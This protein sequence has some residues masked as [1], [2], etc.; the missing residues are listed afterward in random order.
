MEKHKD[1]KIQMGHLEKSKKADVKVKLLPVIT[2]NINEQI[3][4]TQKLSDYNKQQGS[5]ECCLSEENA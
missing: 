1:R 4:L 3:F 5:T 2:L